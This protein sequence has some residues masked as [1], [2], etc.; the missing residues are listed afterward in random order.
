VIAARE[1]LGLSSRLNL[2][3]VFHVP[4]EVVAPD[5]EGIRAGR[6]SKSDGL[7]MVQVALP[8]APPPDADQCLLALTRDAIDLADE[9]ARA[10]GLRDDFSAA[11]SILDAA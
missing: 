8:D 6:F 11:R 5:Y 2:N 9:W 7:L 10:R 1:R 3:V 4:G